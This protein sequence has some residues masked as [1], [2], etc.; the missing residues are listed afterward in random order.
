MATCKRC[1]QSGF[2]LFVDKQGLC[3]TCQEAVQKAVVSS[4][5]KASSQ[6][7]CPYCSQSLEKEPVRK[8]KCKHC[9]NFYYIKRD[10]QDGI[11]KIVTEEQAQAFEQGWV[12]KQKMKELEEWERCKAELAKQLKQQPP[13]WY[14]LNVTYRHLAFIMRKRG[15]PFQ[16][17]LSESLRCQLKSYQQLGLITRVQILAGPNS[18][19]QCKQL[20]GQIFTIQEALEKMPIPVQ[21]TG[22]QDICRCSYNIVI[23]F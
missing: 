14:E 15:E 22:T 16:H 20:D 17:L 4:P 6:F 13:N 8:T 3:K 2:F 5:P 10:P 11:R 1:G 9:G 18:C 23:D 19:P 21:C 7:N 12:Q